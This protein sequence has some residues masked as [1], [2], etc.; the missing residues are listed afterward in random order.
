MRIDVLLRVNFAKLICYYHLLLSR[1]LS[2][3]LACLPV[4][5]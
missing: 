5:R 4:D 1:Q 2:D 3:S